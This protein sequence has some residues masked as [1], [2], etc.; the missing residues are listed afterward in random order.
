[1]IVSRRLALRN[2]RPDLIPL[3]TLNG[4]VTSNCSR[5]PL[6]RVR[7]PKHRAP[8]AKKTWIKVPTAK[9]WKGP[10]HPPGG[11]K[12][13]LRDK[14]RAQGLL[15]ILIFFCRLRRQYI[16]KVSMTL[17]V[18]SLNFCTSA[19]V[20]FYNRVND[21]VKKLTASGGSTLVWNKVPMW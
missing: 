17:I 5:T 2:R 15:Q 13:A 7:R 14:I 9:V 4:F 10:P 19:A 12:E 1:M 6:T 20:Y 3:E 21:V 8:T 16:F 18:E 11:T